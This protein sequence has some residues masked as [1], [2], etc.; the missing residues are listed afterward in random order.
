LYPDFRFAFMYT[1]EAHPGGRL[2]HHA[3]LNQKLANA[4][5][6]ASLH[7]DGWTTLVDDLAGTVHRAYG[8]LPHMVYIINKAGVVFFRSE[9]DDL[10]V[11]RHAM[12][13]LRGVRD[14]R[15]TGERLAPFY[16]EMTGF[17]SFDMLTNLAVVLEAAGPQAVEE[18]IAGLAHKYGEPAAERYREWWAAHRE[19]TG[20]SPK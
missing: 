17:W 7:G 12:E 8:L 3:T 13:Y 5:E 18:Q 1:R 4:R 14:A 16:M 6:M 15:S 10:A 9:A 11:V 19:G 20:E 2:P